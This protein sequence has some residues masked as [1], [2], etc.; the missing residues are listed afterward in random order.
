[1]PGLSQQSRPDHL[2]QV[3]HLPLRI[4]VTSLCMY[5]LLMFKLSNYVKLRQFPPDPDPFPIKTP[6]FQ[7][8]WSTTSVSRVRHLLAR[9]SVIKLPCV[10]ASRR[11]LMIPW[12]CTELG[13]E[14]GV[15]PLGS[16]SVCLPA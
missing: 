11:S 13:I 16:F 8:S 1:M 15:S 12:V 14:W 10:F 4:A 9:S 5:N 6:I 2:S 3:K 7:A